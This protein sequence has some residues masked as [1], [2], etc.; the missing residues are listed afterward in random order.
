MVVQTDAIWCLSAHATCPSC[1]TPVQA[2]ICGV[3]QQLPYHFIKVLDLLGSELELYKEF[4]VVILEIW[5]IL[6]VETS[7]PCRL[8]LSCFL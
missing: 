6:L 4:L 5:D 3:G 8:V 2:I 7:G 1:L